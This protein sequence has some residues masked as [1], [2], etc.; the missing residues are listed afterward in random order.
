MGTCTFGKYSQ[1]GVSTVLH[2]GR[3]VGAFAMVGMIATVTRDVPNFAL[4]YGGPSKTV[5][6]NRI[7]LAR[8]GTS[9]DDINATNDFLIG[10]NKTC[11]ESVLELLRCQMQLA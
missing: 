9:D 2:Q 7:R 5:G 10:L 8:L 6:V 4:S 3:K 1:I 11:P